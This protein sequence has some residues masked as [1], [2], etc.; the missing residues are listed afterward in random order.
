M[1]V[2]SKE[3]EGGKHENGLGDSEQELI[4]HTCFL[5]T[6]LLFMS[7][8][9]LAGTRVVLSNVCRMWSFVTRLS[10][11]EMVDKSRNYLS[12]VNMKGNLGTQNR[13]NW[14]KWFE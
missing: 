3:K 1:V 11:A 14:H 9:R 12:T 2:K 8:I 4:R 13:V 10:N 7:G 6:L 5:L